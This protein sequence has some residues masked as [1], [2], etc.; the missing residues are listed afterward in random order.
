[1]KYDKAGEYMLK[2]TAVDE[3][4]NKKTENRK[5]TVRELSTVLFEDG[6]LIINERYFD[7]EANISAHGSVVKEY[8]P[9]PYYPQSYRPQPWSN[10]N[11]QILKVKMGGEVP[12]PTLQRYFS[13]LYNCTD[14]DLTGAVFEEQGGLHEAFRWCRS[15][16]TVNSELITTVKTS[17]FSDMFQGCESI[18]TIDLSGVGTSWLIMA[19]NMFEDCKSLKTIYVNENWR[20]GGV[21]ADTVMFKSCR[22]LV[23]GAGTTWTEENI[24]QPYSR[25][26]NPTIDEPGYMTVLVWSEA[27]MQNN[28]NIGNSYA[29]IGQPTGE[30]IGGHKAKLII[31]NGKLTID[32]EVIDLPSP[33][34]VTCVVSQS[35]M[36]PQTRVCNFYID[37][38]D[39]RIQISFIFRYDENTVS[40]M[41]TGGAT[42]FTGNIVIE[43]I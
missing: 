38:A 5:I 35:G 18:E 41:V 27:Y 39:K 33:T 16:K 11:G 34:E 15:L 1:M 29:V 10:E 22:N 21:P 8:E 26:D 3:C 36:Y 24:Y 17:N 12:V 42:Q 20:T 37:V 2:Y 19:D 40:A 9:G 14:I 4:G 31:T 23:G 7:R 30:V 43:T 28:A 13:G 6:M 32:G 25:I